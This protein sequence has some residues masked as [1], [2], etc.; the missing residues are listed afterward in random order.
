MKWLLRRIFKRIKQRY[1]IEVYVNGRLISAGPG[2]ITKELES[3]YDA[4]IRIKRVI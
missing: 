2:D 3:E 4:V 1:P